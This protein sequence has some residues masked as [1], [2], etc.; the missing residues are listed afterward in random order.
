MSLALVYVLCCII[1]HFVTTSCSSVARH[2][3]HLRLFII[4]NNIVVNTLSL[5]FFTRICPECI[6]RSR[7]VGSQHTCK[8]KFTSWCRI[9]TD[10]VVW[11]PLPSAGLGRTCAHIFTST[12]VSSECFIFVNLKEGNGIRLCFQFE[13]FLVTSA[14][15]LLFLYSFTCSGV[16]SSGIS[17]HQP[18]PRSYECTTPPEDKWSSGLSTA[19]PGHLMGLTGRD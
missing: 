5:L 2:L 8:C 15:E 12:W 6:I 3:N 10:W 9:A 1:F 7:T 4:T 14:V 11:L 16:S 18:E 13:F 19:E 17:V